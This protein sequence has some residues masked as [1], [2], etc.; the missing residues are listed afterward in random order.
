MDNLPTELTAAGGAGFEKLLIGSALSHGRPALDAV[1]EHLVPVPSFRCK[2]EDY[3]HADIW[4]ALCELYESKVPIDM[5]MV[6]IQ[7]CGSS[8]QNVGLVAVMAETLNWATGSVKNLPTLCEKFLEYRRKDHLANRLSELITRATEENFSEKAEDIEN[9]MAALLQNGHDDHRS[10]ML[11]DILPDVIEDFM[12]GRND[13]TPTGLTDLDALIRGLEAGRLYVL[14]GRPGMGKSALAVTWAQHFATLGIPVG[15]LSLEMSSHE[16][17]ARF[18]TSTGRMSF[19][20][21]AAGQ[22]PHDGVLR[23]IA[24]IANEISHLPIVIDDAAAMP[25]SHVLARG[26]AWRHRNK[27]GLLVID[28]LLLIQHEGENRTQAVGEITRSLKGLTKE[29]GIP[30]LAL[31]Q[32]NRGVEGRSDKRPM[33]ADLRDSGNI[34]QDADVVIFIYRPHFYGITEEGVPLKNSCEL[35]V[36]KNRSG[37]TGTANVFCDISTGFF[38]NADLVRRDND[39]RGNGTYGVPSKTRDMQSGVRTPN[40]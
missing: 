29:I 26:R 37:P 9:K 40:D 36:A 38:G 4:T 19:H 5:M 20:T 31:S 33:L 17:V 22:A 23:K 39:N 25:L 7:I 16:V 35:I 24:E 15:F 12:S 10:T 14:A 32:L 34:E 18:L 1:F 28:H 30:V 21:L 27:I 3:R 8:R 6:Y 11:S 2:T 13:A